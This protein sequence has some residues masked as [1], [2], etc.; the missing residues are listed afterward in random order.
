MSDL[1]TG[2]KFTIVSSSVD[3]SGKVSPHFQDSIWSL[4]NFSQKLKL[5][6]VNN[7]Y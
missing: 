6:T 5:D 3:L 1:L 7:H 4:L 2:I